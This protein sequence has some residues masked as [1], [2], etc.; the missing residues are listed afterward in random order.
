MLYFI[1]LTFQLGKIKIKDDSA[2]EMSDW[3]RIRE[4]AMA[5]VIIC[6]INLITI[7]SPINNLLIQIAIVI[8]RKHLE[9]QPDEYPKRFIDIIIPNQFNPVAYEQVSYH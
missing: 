3:Y 5:Q 9:L 2:I 1:S 6:S 7:Y 8:L 4:L